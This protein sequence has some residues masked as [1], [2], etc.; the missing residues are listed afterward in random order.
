DPRLLHSLPPRRSSD[1]LHAPRRA[2]GARVKILYLC[3]RVPW[4]PD[5]GDRFRSFAVL[6]W[7]AKRHE[8]FVG[9]FADGG[10]PEESRRATVALRSAEQT[11]ELQ[12]RWHVG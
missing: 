4:P 8:V 1:L 5:K 2:A 7:L 12:S 6:Q 9:A 10:D 11:S 3:H